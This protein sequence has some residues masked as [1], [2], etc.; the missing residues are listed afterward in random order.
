MSY[1]NFSLEKLRD[2]FGINNRKQRL[3][4][5]TNVKPIEPSSWLKESLE[6]GRMLPNRS[7]K[8]KSETLVS[9]ILIELKKNNNTF[10]TIHSGDHLNADPK[11]GLNG[12]CDF[13]IGK[14]THSL[15][16]DAPLFSVVEAKKQDFDLGI[17][18]CAAQ[19]YGTK[20]F[21]EKHNVFFETIYGVVTSADLWL[22]LKLE[23][24]TI[25]IANDEDRLSLKDIALILGR[26]QFIVD[27]Y[28]KL[29]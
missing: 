1:K 2:D 6:Y 24:S 16:I 25:I 19:M 15:T 14:E 13:I 10:I 18:Q 3:T 9:P 17:A 22:F 11:K 26:L 12:E 7:E 21:N 4:E 23:N 27:F 20:L 8:A 28:K 5:F 29:V